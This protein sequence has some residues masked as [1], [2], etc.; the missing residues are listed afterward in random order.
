[1]EAT[2]HHSTEGKE[3]T[4][5]LPVVLC[6]DLGMWIPGVVNYQ[7]YMGL[8]K[9]INKLVNRYSKITYTL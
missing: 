7:E 6:A 3:T 1:M 8:I 9:I 4:P 5:L 2:E